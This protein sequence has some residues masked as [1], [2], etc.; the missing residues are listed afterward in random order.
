M[1]EYY[2]LQV[3]YKFHDHCREALH[4]MILVK[5]ILSY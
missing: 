1:V 2:E 4:G 5:S 3:E